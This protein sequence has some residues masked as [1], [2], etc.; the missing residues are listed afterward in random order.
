MRNIGLTFL[1][2]LLKNLIFHSLH[3][4]TEKETQKES[5]MKKKTPKT[6]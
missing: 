3:C 1:G 6:S 2:L 5:E 4:V